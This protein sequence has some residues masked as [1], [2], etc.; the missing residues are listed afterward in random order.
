MGSIFI[1][2]KHEITQVSI[3]LTLFVRFTQWCSGIGLY[4]LQKA[5]F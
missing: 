5:D 2:D 3:L 1:L 4:Q